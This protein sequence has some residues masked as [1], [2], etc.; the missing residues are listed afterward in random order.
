MTILEYHRTRTKLVDIVKVA[1]SVGIYMYVV[2]LLGCM[3]IQDVTLSV[4]LQAKGKAS[5]LKLLTINREILDTF[6]QLGQ[7]WNLSR[8]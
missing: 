2:L 3:H 4:R 5:A 1:V 7:M 8:E 6:L